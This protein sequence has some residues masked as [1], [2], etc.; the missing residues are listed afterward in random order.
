MR[1]RFIRHS[2]EAGIGITL[3][4]VLAWAVAAGYEE[5]RFVYQGF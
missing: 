4:L 3:A 2:L 5:V 1:T